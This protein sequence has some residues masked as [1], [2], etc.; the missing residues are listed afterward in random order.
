[1]HV[2]TAWQNREDFATVAIRHDNKVI[3]RQSV[4]YDI[5]SSFTKTRNESY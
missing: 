3:K 2:I 5:A 4:R 1:M